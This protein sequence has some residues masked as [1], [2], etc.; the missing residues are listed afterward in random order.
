[1]STCSSSPALDVAAWLAASS[2]VES[3]SDSLSDVIEADVGVLGIADV[4]YG[5][6]TS[7]PGSF[8]GTWE[9]WFE[10]LLFNVQG[11]FA[12]ASSGNKAGSVD[13]PCDT[14]LEVLAPRV[15]VRSVLRESL[16]LV[17]SSG[18]KA[19][20]SVSARLCTPYALCSSYL[21]EA[22]AA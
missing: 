9:P 1:M 22:A 2:M 7:A 11:R 20:S 15:L 6:D 12:L 5:E 19:A 4:G 21:D 17:A 8:K 18:P 3:S 16:P 14:D 13:E 10:G